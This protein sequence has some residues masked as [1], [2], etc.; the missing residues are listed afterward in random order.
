MRRLKE[1]EKQENKRQVGNNVKYPI[2][3]TKS[4]SKSKSQSVK[5]YGGLAFKHWDFPVRRT[6]ILVPL[7]RNN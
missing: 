4:M 2:S 6:R 7:G 5:Q 1:R 3:N